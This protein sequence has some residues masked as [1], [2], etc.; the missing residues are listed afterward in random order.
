MRVERARTDDAA[1]VRALVEEAAEW[2]T[3]RGI[4]QWRPGALPDFVIPRGIAHG[5]VF[6]V[7]AGEKLAASVT[8]EDEDV[9]TWGPSD[10]TALY[11]H[12]LV[13]ARAHAGSGLG[14][15]LLAWAR[16]ETVARGKSAL[17][18]DCVAS[19]AFLRSYYP[20]QGFA[21]RGEVTVGPVTLARFELTSLAPS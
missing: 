15:R 11:L 21:E 19:N 7:R 2:L 16:G 3:A 17:R 8:L 10:G 20:G 6:V 12:R 4:R 5:D 18:L 14:P 13:V 9:P 1:A